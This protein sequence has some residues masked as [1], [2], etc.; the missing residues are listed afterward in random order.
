MYP[1]IDFCVDARAVYD[2]ISASDVCELAV[3][4]FKLHLISVGDRMA[5]G[6]IR[7]LFWVDARHMLA[8]GL[9]KGNID[10]LFLHICS[11]DCKYVSKHESLRHSKTFGTSATKPQQEIEEELLE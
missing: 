11:N 3:S 9:M 7:N 8:D 1:Q 4:S 10:R 2:A 6:L 5:H